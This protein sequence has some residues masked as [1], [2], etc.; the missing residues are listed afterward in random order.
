M[1]AT[2]LAY[3]LQ[4]AADFSGE[5]YHVNKCLVETYSKM[6]TFEKPPKFL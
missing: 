1:Y 3:V 4:V 5:N 2:S 6:D